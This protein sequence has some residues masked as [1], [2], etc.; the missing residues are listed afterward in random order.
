MYKILVCGGRGYAD[1][2]YLY[3]VLDSLDALT[4]IDMVIHG[5]ARGAD[6]LGGQWARDRGRG[7]AAVPANW[8]FYGRKAGYIR[9]TWMAELGPDTVVAF[10]GGTGTTM[11][12]DIAT[13]YRIPVW[14]A[15]EPT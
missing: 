6:E 3:T 9:N 10:P 11:M 12:K 15:E 8:D 2:E 13:R 4:R 1:K 14:D 5:G 7:C